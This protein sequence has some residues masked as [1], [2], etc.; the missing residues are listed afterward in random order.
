[1]PPVSSHMIQLLLYTRRSVHAADTDLTANNSQTV[2]SLLTVLVAVCVVSLHR[3]PTRSVLCRYEGLV[4]S[5]FIVVKL[6]SS[7]LYLQKR[8]LWELTE[9]LVQPNGWQVLQKC[10]PVDGVKL[11][12]ETRPARNEERTLVADSTVILDCLRKVLT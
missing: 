11:F 1:M 9:C 10:S 6:S 12:A 5:V 2:V 4:S 3:S 8:K 7:W